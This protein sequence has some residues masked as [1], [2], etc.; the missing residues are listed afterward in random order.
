M[1]RGKSS[2][3]HPTIETRARYEGV[4]RRRIVPRDAGA[5]G[6]TRTGV[7]DRSSGAPGQKTACRSSSTTLRSSSE[8]F[9]AGESIA[10]IEG[11]EIF[12]K[13]SPGISVFT[14]NTPSGPLRAVALAK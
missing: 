2:G 7:A 10:L 12:T 8:N 11:F 13:Y 1:R 3:L 14:V 5:P 4:L 6:L 9:G